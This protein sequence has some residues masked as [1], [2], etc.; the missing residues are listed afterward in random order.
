MINLFKETQMK[1]TQETKSLLRLILIGIA[2]L[3]MKGLA[4]A[5][6]EK[7]DLSI[8]QA[9]FTKSKKSIIS[10]YLKIE[11]S[12]QNASFWRMYD[13]YEVN[14]KSIVMERMSILSDYMDNYFAI[15]DDKASRITEK[16]MTSDQ[17]M[18]A[19]DKKYFKSF[20]KIVGSKQ[21][22]K[23]FQIEQYIQTVMFASVLAQTPILDELEVF[24][25]PSID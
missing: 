24:S 10:T 12:D 3:S 2:I 21:A 22:M 16:L 4:F 14:R 9:L 25:I 20:S 5:Q 8:A 7:E 6:T 13:Q 11:N 23:L 19:L 17:R 18:N 15:D 1:N